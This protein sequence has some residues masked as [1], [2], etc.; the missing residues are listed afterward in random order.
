MGTLRTDVAAVTERWSRSQTI[1]SIFGQSAAGCKAK[2]VQ[3]REPPFF[4]FSVIFM[5]D[6]PFCREF[7]GGPPTLA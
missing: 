3:R 1:K 5:A 6:W 4:I 7:L 2:V